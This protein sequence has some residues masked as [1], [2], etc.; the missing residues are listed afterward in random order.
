MLQA[1]FSTSDTLLV[2]G[3]ASIL[4]YDTPANLAAEARVDRDELLV[5]FSVS[6][7]HRLSRYLD[8][9][10]ALD[11]NLNHIVYLFG[12]WSGNN[13]YN[14]ILRFSPTTTYRPTGAISSTNV[15]EVL[16]N[17]TVY[18]YEQVVSDAHSYSYR[19]FRWMDS[20]SV[21]FT[22]RIGLDF[23]NDLKLYERGQ[24]RWSDF[25][26]RT[27]NSFVDRTISSQV[28]FRP[29][30]DLLFAM[31]LR[32]FGQSRYTFDTGVKKLDSFI[33]SLGPTCLILW[34]VG[35]HSRV[36][37][38]GW[39]ERRTFSGSQTSS[40]LTR[41]LPNLTMNISINL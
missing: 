9:G 26:E 22:T 29:E 15:F 25:S 17:Y 30:R 33:E 27:E 20:S 39:Y 13:R 24:L 41:A 19:Q 28:R 4:R 7:V 12:N 23:F 5:A 35:V 34:D 1:P 8:L 21:E 18:D 16:A 11:G 36:M 6:T 2:S 31:G 3:A 32:Y 10:F 14:R 37:F 38:K 40:E